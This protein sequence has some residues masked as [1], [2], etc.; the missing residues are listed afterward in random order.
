MNRVELKEKAK[1][2]LKGKYGECIKMMLIYLGIS[3]V[4]SLVVGIITGLFSLSKETQEIIKSIVS[5]L[6]AGLLA[7]GQLSFYVK[8]SRNE[9]VTYEELFSKTHLFVPY[10]VISI[11]V[12]IFVTLWSILF[13]IP[14]I[15]AALSYSLVFFILLDNPEIGAMDA[16]KKS[17]EMMKGHKLD[18]FVLQ[19]SFIG[20]MILG[21]FTIGILYLWLIPYMSVTEANFYNA[22]KNNN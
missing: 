1:A 17:K 7:L 9:E 3:F 19:L 20:W 14:G 13:I 6:I 21:V 15:I 10:I 2:S 11:L 5:V 16:I 4:I 22:L 12:G 8:I 18:F